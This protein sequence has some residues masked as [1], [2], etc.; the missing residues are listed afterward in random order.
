MQILVQDYTNNICDD[1]HM[2]TTYIMER[3]SVR[4]L[5][6]L[7][8]WDNFDDIYVLICYSHR[9]EFNRSEE[10]IVEQCCDYLIE[11]LHKINLF[12]DGNK[13]GSRILKDIPRAKIVPTINTA[14]NGKDRTPLH[15]AADCV[16]IDRFSSGY[17]RSKWIEY[18]KISPYARGLHDHNKVA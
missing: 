9:K 7:V 17:L 11:L 10:K 1:T 15:S 3:F 2:L 6:C 5:C 4:L 14:K 16:F 12:F 13:Q 18:Y 8:P